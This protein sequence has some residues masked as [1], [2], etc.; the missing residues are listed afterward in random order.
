MS[1][2]D[3]V[4][5]PLHILL[6][7]RF[8]ELNENQEELLRDARTAADSMD[9]ALRRL[10][11]VADADRDALVVQRELVQVNDVLRAVLPLARAAAERAGARVEAALE[12]G[13]PRVPADRAR[14]AEAL[15]LLVD[16]ASGAVSSAVPLALATL[17]ENGGV[18]ITVAPLARRPPAEEELDAGAS[19]P[20]APKAGPSLPPSV[21]A[22]RLVTCQEGTLERTSAGIIVR[23][24]Q[25]SGA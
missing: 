19:S 9:A 11:Q 5:L 22:E 4:R 15:A 24:G 8:G 7:T 14:L 21:L 12:P 20:V 1:Q 3:E 6:D 18:S 16:D 13:L 2:L 23:L 25:K 10:G 17:R